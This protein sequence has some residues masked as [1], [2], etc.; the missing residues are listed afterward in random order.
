MKYFKVVVV[1]VLV[2]IISGCGT[3]QVDNQ[4][5][6]ELETKLIEM[7]MERIQGIKDVLVEQFQKGFEIKSKEADLDLSGLTSTQS[8]IYFLKLS[9]NECESC[10][11]TSI[12]ILKKYKRTNPDKH[13]G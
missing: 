1:I 13:V 11:V 3:K 10:V 2:G 12:S 5:L 9:N 6:T 8:P 4:R 7:E